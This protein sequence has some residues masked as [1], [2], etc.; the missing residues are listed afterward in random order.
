MW[1]QAGFWVLKQIRISVSVVFC[2]W[3]DDEW[4]RWDH[5]SLFYIANRELFQ[6]PGTKFVLRAEPDVS[7]SI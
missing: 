2:I 7:K 1:G 4:R 6:H 3:G 5:C